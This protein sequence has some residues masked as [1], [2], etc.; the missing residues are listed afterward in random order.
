MKQVVSYIDIDSSLADISMA[1]NGLLN[2]PGDLKQVY[3]QYNFNVK[4]D[5]TLERSPEKQ[6][7]NV[8]YNAFTDFAFQL[9]EIS[10]TKTRVNYTLTYSRKSRFILGIIF[11]VFFGSLILLL[12]ISIIAELISGSLFMLPMLLPLLFLILFLTVLWVSLLNGARP[13][14]MNNLFH[15]QFLSRLQQYIEIVEAHKQKKQ[16]QNISQ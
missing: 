7:L 6:G 1:F 15:K 2:I 5:Q 13:K 3:D 8:V 16:A 14:N 4:K 11:T 10:P 9:S 12:G